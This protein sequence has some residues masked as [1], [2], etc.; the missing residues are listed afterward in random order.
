MHTTHDTRHTTHGVSLHA[1]EKCRKKRS[2]VPGVGD[3]DDVAHVGEDDLEELVHVDAAGVGEAEQRV[4]GE[5]RRVAHHTRVQQ[6][7]ERK[8]R[9]RLRHTSVRVVGRWSCRVVFRTP[10]AWTMS[11]CSRRRT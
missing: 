11:I 3:A 1:K 8:R 9:E 5:D 10:W 2:G 7:L 6:R 4:V